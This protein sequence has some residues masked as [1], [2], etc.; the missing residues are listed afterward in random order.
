MEFV[1]KEYKNIGETVYAAELPNGLRVR[2]IPKPDFS[3]TYA[4]FGTAYGGS[5]RC[6]SVNGEKR[7]TPA[8]VAHFLEHKMFDMPSGENALNV[9]SENGADPNAFTSS[10]Y[11][12]Y[13]FRCT[14]GYEDNL[15]L[16]L[17]FVSTPYFTPETV[18]KEQGIIGQEIRMG[19][20]SPGSAVYY[21]LLNCL[22]ARHP[23]RDRVA[24]TID[25][26]AQITDRTLYDCHKV[27]YTPA[28]MVLCVEGN[29]DPETVCAIAQQVL[30]A[31]KS[32]VPAADFGEPEDGLPVCQKAEA[33]MAVSS[34]LFIVGCKNACASVEKGEQDLKER[35]VSAV[36]L[37][38]LAGPSSRLF[39]TLYEAGTI[40]N[41]IDAECDYAAG[42]STVLLSAE[43]PDPE[44]FL[45]ELLLESEAAAE[46][47]FE[48]DYFDRTL[49]AMIGSH[50]RSSEDF[51]ELCL[52]TALGLLD[53][54][55][56][57]EA[58]DLLKSVTKADCED[59]IRCNFRPE[60]L[61][62]SVIRP[63]T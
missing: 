57:F 11:T 37:R 55:D 5:M 31:E 30:P 24:G 20:D 1:R 38:L 9:F 28:N 59:W 54:Y 10:A 29:V 33:K 56:F 6:F 21:N 45:K 46:K 12:C 47:G 4:V 44:E 40:F 63:A 36:A 13:H 14:E 50:L 43:G 27:F 52:S 41:S 48:Q 16:L 19:E 62:L 7:D 23:I 22:Y 25:S 53:G 35:S 26:I 60:R 18:E 2:I 58:Y 8:G 39:S 42:T 49:K 17:E 32:P 15:K 51:E 34:P 61:A 3:T